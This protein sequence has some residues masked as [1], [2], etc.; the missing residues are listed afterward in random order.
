MASA[1]LY[2]SFVIFIVVTL[3]S[4]IR[5]YQLSGEDPFD[6]PEDAGGCPINFC[7]M[8]TSI[9]SAFGIMVGAILWVAQIAWL[10]S[11]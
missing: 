7:L 5:F 10:E 9:G 3:V 4:C 1:I 11:F 6:L 8:W 2:K